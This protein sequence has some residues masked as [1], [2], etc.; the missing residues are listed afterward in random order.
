MASPSSLNGS[1]S[2][3]AMSIVRVA[4]LALGD[5]D[6]GRITDMVLP[7]ELPLREILPAVRRMA[8][9]DDGDG[10]H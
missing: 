5:G 10:D 3:K 2:M 1:A 6:G 7:T 9:P 4:V 8:M